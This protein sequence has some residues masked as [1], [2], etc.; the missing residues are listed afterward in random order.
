[1]SFRPLGKR[2]L[3]EEIIESEK[4]EGSII[5]PNNVS[6][7][8]SEGFIRYIGDEVTKV[9][10]GDKVLFPANAGNELKQDGVTMKLMLEA[11]IEAII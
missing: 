11:T 10:V 1:M 3:V 7:V 4:K 2:L 9:S 8:F 5:I 6:K